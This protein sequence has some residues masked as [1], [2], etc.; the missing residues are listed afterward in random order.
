[1]KLPAFIRRAIAWLAGLWASL[2]RE[3]RD[4]AAALPLT[5]GP[6]STSDRIAAIDAALAAGTNTIDCAGERMTFG[7]S[8]ELLRE[9]D[10]L[11][12]QQPERN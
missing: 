3:M 2:K 4:Q 6:T 1:M 12:R 8:L 11:M 7:S 9:R 10:R 5:A